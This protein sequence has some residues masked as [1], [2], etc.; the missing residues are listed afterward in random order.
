ML[1]YSYNLV[2]VL[3]L[4]HYWLNQCYV[5]NKTVESWNIKNISNWFNNR[6]PY[7]I[8]RIMGPIQFSNS[9]AFW[10]VEFDDGQL[11]K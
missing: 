8:Q 4:L 10:I 9:T 3:S 2:V 11:I 1:I 5:F 7:Q 6:V